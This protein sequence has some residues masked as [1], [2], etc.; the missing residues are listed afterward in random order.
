MVM[1]ELSAKTD[2]AVLG[3]GPGGYAAAFHAADLG[4]EVTLVSQEERMGGVCL[5]RGCIPSKALL[6]VTELQ[7]TVR[8]AS[9]MGLGSGGLDI[10]VER[11]RAWKNE[12]VERL[13]GG[14]EKLC[15]ARGVRWIKARGTFDGSSALRLE[16]GDLRKLE[17][18]NAVIAT[19]SRPISLP[20]SAFGDRIWD[21]AKTLEL[22]EIPETL[23]VVGGGYVGLEMGTVYATLGSRVTLIEMTDR[24]LPNADED[25]VGPLSSELET[26]LEEIRLNARVS[27]L[28]ESSE[29]VRVSLEDEGELGTFDRILVAIGRRPN[30]ESLGLDSTA[31]EVDD[32]GFVRIDDRCRTKEE[33]IFGI[34]DVAGGKLLAHEAMRQGRVAAE[35][36]AGR[37]DAF[38]A[39]AVPAVVYTDPQVA[40]CGLTET[41][42]K[43]QGRDVEVSRFPWTASGRAVSM[44]VSKGMTKLLIDPETQRILGVGIVGRE[45]EAL[46]AE[47]AL[48]IEMGARARDLGSTIHPHPTLSETLGEA[49]EA[50]LGGATHARIRAG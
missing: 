17:F 47:G 26:M 21:S 1:G 16:G 29:G 24:I 23:L 36:A 42:A 25:L 41:E 12:V 28:E 10:D 18:A 45:A 38:D 11:L 19:G 8:R 34:G 48:A 20:G 7:R 22:P 6:F 31:V 4:K 32:R 27:E 9:D 14:L 46:I 44:G 5:R 13:T 35:A 40:W 50:F 3:G 30:S 43:A 2:V 49:A 37:P 15:E 33:N 39:R